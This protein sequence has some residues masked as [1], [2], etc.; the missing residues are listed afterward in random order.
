MMV[1]N[2]IRSNDARSSARTTGYDAIVIGGGSPG[3]LAGPSD[4]VDP[5]ARE[6]V[7]LAGVGIVRDHDIPPRE[8]GR[9]VDLRGG[10][11]LARLID[12]LA[13]TKQ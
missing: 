13:W 6:P 10:A 8:G 4:Q 11:C 9:D 5:L 1:T 7:Q 3:E 12:R 2:E